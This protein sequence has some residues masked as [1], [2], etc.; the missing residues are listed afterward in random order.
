MSRLLNDRS[1]RI[2]IYILQWRPSFGFES[3]MSSTLLTSDDR[4]V[5][6]VDRKA[7]CLFARVAVPTMSFLVGSA[8]SAAPVYGNSLS[9]RII[10]SA[11]W[12]QMR[13]TH[14]CGRPWL[15]RLSPASGAAA[16]SRHRVTTDRNRCHIQYP[17]VGPR[18]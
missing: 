16:G 13:R 2:S 17:V 3:S 10:R 15:Q 11:N 6:A 9:R 12:Q 5:T 1:H 4:V 7:V 8:S 18:C 14:G